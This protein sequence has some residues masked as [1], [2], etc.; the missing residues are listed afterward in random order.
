M[1]LLIIPVLKRW[2]RARGPYGYL[3]TWNWPITARE[4]SQPYNK[5]QYNLISIFPF[6]GFSALGKRFRSYR[7]LWDLIG[8]LY[9]A[10]MLISHDVIIFD[11]KRLKLDLQNGK[12]WNK[13]F[14]LI[15]SDFNFQHWLSSCSLWICYFPIFQD[16]GPITAIFSVIK[17]VA[18]RWHLE[19]L[20]VLIPVDVWCPAFLL[21]WRYST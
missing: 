16:T 14:R 12:I 6:K 15:F 7:N 19:P 4:I 21:K 1:A 3:R 18:Y 20:K 11:V 8:P 2:S 10:Q 13:L 17:I 5:I 9:I